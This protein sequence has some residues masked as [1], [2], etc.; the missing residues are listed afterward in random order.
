MDDV[1]LALVLATGLSFAL[2][3]IDV[4]GESKASL[5]PILS[6]LLFWLYLFILGVGN[7]A[8][9]LASASL[10]D[11]YFAKTE[12][13]SDS[14]EGGL[15]RGDDNVARSRD[16]SD[17]VG[18]GEDGHTILTLPGR[19]WFWYAFFGVFGFQG[20]LKRVNVTFAEA[21]VLS[22][23]DWITKSRDAAAANAIEQQVRT[24]A[25]KAASHIEVLKTLPLDQLRSHLLSSGT[26]V[27]KIEQ[28]ATAAN[29]DIALMLATEFA[30]GDPEKARALVLQLTARGNK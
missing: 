14:Q 27:E 15:A 9:T 21:G 12:A 4:R 22:I 10:V 11:A 23:H 24:D 30:F 16:S 6:S 13:D 19:L 18:S 1:T 8:S 7:A 2:A 26:D 17:R 28:R 25:A 29:A 20:V 3:L 5:G